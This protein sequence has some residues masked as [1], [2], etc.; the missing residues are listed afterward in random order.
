MKRH[1]QYKPMMWDKFCRILRSSLEYNNVEGDAE[2]DI[3]FNTWKI[4][5]KTLQYLESEIG[6]GIKNGYEET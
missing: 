1:E 4:L 3:Y 6:I 2:R 5:T